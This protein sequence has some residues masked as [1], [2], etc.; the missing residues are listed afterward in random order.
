M[1]KFTF[2]KAL[3][4]ALDLPEKGGRDYYYD[5]KERHLML[6]VTSKGTKTFYV[7]RKIDGKPERIFIGLFPD[8]TIDQARN[9]AVELK[10]KIAQGIN[11]NTEKQSKQG[12]LFGDFF[13]NE[14]IEKH[15]KEHKKT[16]E[17][18][19]TCYNRFFIKFKNTELSKITVTD[20]RIMHDEISKTSGKFMANR[21]LD[22]LKSAY[23]K[24]VSWGI[25]SE[26]PAV[27]ITKFKEKSRDRFINPE[28][29]P[30]FFESLD[31]EPNVVIRDY[32]Y[33]SLIT[34]ARRANVLS[35]K[36]EDI[37]FNAKTWYI[38]ETKNGE[39]Q[40]IPLVDKAIEI[41][42]TIKET[43]KSKFVFPANSAVGHLVEPKSAWKRIL[44]RAGIEQ[45][46][47]TSQN[48]RL[49]DL[50]RS[51]GSYLAMTGAS[52]FVIG[53]ALN[54]KSQAATA[55]YARMNIDP[56][57]EAMEGAVGKMFGDGGKGKVEE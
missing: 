29:L 12:I 35:M 5:E 36:W 44:Q 56:V 34:G 38:K 55:I 57:R 24:A 23:N 21:A 49:H 43:N 48:L 18:D 20:I 7:Y 16:W 42:Q 30:K 50:R 11:P 13:V 41:L 47:D 1:K 52:N 54:H 39:H 40:T 31:A 51:M 8:L 14:Y 46:A 3:L 9:K 17:Y 27:G 53:K 2:T 45:S 22:I 6:A 28:E 25:A 33:I 4:S 37:N 15:A 32:I 26:N 19:L 10:N